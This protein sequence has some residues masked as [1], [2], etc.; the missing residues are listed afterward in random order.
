METVIGIGS[1]WSVI[2]RDHWRQIVFGLV[3]QDIAAGASGCDQDSRSRRE[4]RGKAA[5]G[6]R[7]PKPGG[8][9]C[10]SLSR[11]ASW[12]AAAL[13]RFSPRLLP[14][15]DTSDR[16]RRVLAIP[17]PTLQNSPVVVWAMKTR[18]LLVATIGF[19][20][21]AAGLLWWGSNAKPG[22]PQSPQPEPV[23]V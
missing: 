5:E 4:V 6:C 19:A 14:M 3:T 8:T 16:T 18:T 2:P 1:P 23:E 9:S 22:P 17:T 20:L 15:P 12:S 7:T 21:L 11:E 10:C 13:C